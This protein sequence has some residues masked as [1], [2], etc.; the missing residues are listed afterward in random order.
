MTLCHSVS[1]LSQFLFVII[2]V[3]IM[4]ENLPQL[5]YTYPDDNCANRMYID[6]LLYRLPLV[7]RDF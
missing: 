7:S 4:T 6:F 3:F 1:K 2:T 5:Y